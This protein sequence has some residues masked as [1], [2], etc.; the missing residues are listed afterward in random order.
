M[1]AI[2][3]PHYLELSRDFDPD[4]SFPDPHYVKP[5]PFKTILTHI[6]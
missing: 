1:I 2:L 4:Y 6:I 5:D 3:G